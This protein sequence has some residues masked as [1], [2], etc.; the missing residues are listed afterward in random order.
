MS[1]ELHRAEL[2]VVL[3]D[4]FDNIGYG[5]AAATNDDILRELEITDEMV[6][7][8]AGLLSTI[9]IQPSKMH[10]EHMIETARVALEMLVRSADGG[11]EE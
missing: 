6:Q 3:R 5:H 11:E 8:L 7:L 4:Q 9:P 10:P 1:A 2:E